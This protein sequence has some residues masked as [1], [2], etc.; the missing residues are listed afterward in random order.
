MS[1]M[2]YLYL[3]ASS[4]SFS[5]M[6]MD[7][8]KVLY[9]TK[10][11]Y[12]YL[13]EIDSLFLWDEINTDLLEEHDNINRSG[14]F[15]AA[16]IKIMRK[17]KAPF[18]MVDNDL[19]FNCDVLKYHDFNDNDIIVSHLELGWNYYINTDDLIIKKS[20]IKNTFPRDLN[21]LAYN[22]SFLY[23]KND[24]IRE[25]Y[26]EM[27]YDWMS[28][29]SM[30]CGGSGDHMIFCEQKLLYDIAKAEGIKVKTLINYPFS[31]FFK[32]FFPVGF[33]NRERSGF[34]RVSPVPDEIAGECINH[35]GEGKSRMVTDN[36]YYEERKNDVIIQISRYDI[37]KNV[38]SIAFN[39]KNSRYENS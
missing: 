33:S 28:K 39:I 26:S 25:L 38:L 32:K 8:K 37:C 30:C 14:F 36:K 29:I 3:A 19:F 4:L 6:F 11:V 5:R 1:E 18:I 27:S 2:E 16:K 12:Q 7:I 35:L 22:V 31:C 17:V 34:S 9:C 21:G 10:D 20:G 23:I 24:S 13:K 15:A